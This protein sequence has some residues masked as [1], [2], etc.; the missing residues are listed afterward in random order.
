MDGEVQVVAVA[1][2]TAKGQV[3]IPSKVRSLLG[4][5]EGDAVLFEYVDGE[6]RLVPVRR[7][8]PS[9][10]IGLLPATRPYPGTEAVRR[11]VQQHLATQWGLREDKGE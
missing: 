3:T 5:R 2:V 7:R 9:E 4:I 10:L 8:K 11:A 6:V 1:R